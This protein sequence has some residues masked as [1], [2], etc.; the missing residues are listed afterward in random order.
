[1]S[2]TRSL[3]RPVVAALESAKILGVRSG[4]EHRYT[5]VWVVVV[6]GR[7]FARSWS[8]QPTGWYRAFVEE[9]LGTIQMPGGREVRVRAKKVRGERLLDA[10][11]DAYGK[12]YNT[13]ASLK[14]V[15]G[16]A[17]A[18]RRATTIEFVPR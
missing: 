8:D 12:K 17:Q 9:P 16:F 2:A 3:S 5:G 4:T 13:R 10:I 7:A 11:D 15:R 1:M 14:W 18:K 6:K